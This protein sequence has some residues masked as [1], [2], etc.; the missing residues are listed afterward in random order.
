MMTPILLDTHIV[1]WTLL[2]PHKLSENIKSVIWDA[3]NINN[4]M[5]SSITLWEI[6][7]LASKKRIN[8][9]ETIESFV[10]SITQIPGLS[11]V[12]I[13]AKIAAQSVSIANNFHLDPSDRIITATAICHK[14]TLVTKDQKILQWSQDQ[15]VK[16]IY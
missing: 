10:D 15:R 6:A 13:S 4:L 3:Q 2:E 7:M 16:T 1:L 12:D 14:A 8:I 5:I 9:H 11:V